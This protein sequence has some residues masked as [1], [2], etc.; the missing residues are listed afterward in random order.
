MPLELL[1]S[2]HKEEAFISKAQPA[3][4]QVREEVGS[5]SCEALTMIVDISSHSIDLSSLWSSSDDCSS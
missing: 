5:S 1:E 2:V 4:L 3:H